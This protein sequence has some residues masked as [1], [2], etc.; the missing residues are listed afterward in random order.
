MGPAGEAYLVDFATAVRLREGDR[1]LRRFLFER[2]R[3]IDR[4]TFAR[5]KA[6]Y[7]SASL[8]PDERAWLEAEPWYLKLGRLLKRRVYRLR[9]R[10]FWRDLRRR[11][12]RWRRRKGEGKR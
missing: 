6:S 7:D 1:P 2:C 8:D 3:R 5:I 12:Q 9:K 10:R 4:I 11:L